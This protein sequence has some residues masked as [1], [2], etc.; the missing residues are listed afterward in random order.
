MVDWRPKSAH[1]LCDKI[2]SV[3]A[4]ALFWGN[5]CG[6]LK[7]KLSHFQRVNHVLSFACPVLVFSCMPLSCLH[8]MVHLLCLSAVNL[9]ASNFLRI[10]CCLDMLNVSKW[11][12]KKLICRHSHLNGE[13]LKLVMS[14]S[15]WISFGFPRTRK[16]FQNRNQFHFQICHLGHNYRSTSY[17]ICTF[18][19]STK[20]FKLVLI[21]ME[22]L[23]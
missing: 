11:S 20:I 21:L 19:A 6:D 3:H 22:Y 10:V 7:K 9:R 2:C 8:W 16:V 4:I 17:L 18:I 5:M 12:C 14:N 23:S 13:C 15:M 1:F